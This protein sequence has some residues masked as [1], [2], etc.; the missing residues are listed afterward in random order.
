M[1]K[2]LDNQQGRS[3]DGG[4][5]SEKTG[6][7]FSDP[8]VELRSHIEAHDGDAA[9]SHADD[10]GDNDLEEL[11]DDAHHRHGDLRILFLTEDGVKGA[12]FAN[13]VVDGRHG[14]Y[15]RDLRQK[16]AKSQGKGAADDL[17][18]Q[19]EVGELE[20]YNSCP[21]EVADG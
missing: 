16:A 21:E 17:I 15:Q 20:R 4:F 5:A 3:A 9:G 10:D 7:Q 6:E 13:H 2:N 1:G 19:A 8:P 11:H 14:R 18:L 12:V